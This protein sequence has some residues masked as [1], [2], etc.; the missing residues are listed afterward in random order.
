M[1][2]KSAV[3]TFGEECSVLVWRWRKTE[4]RRFAGDVERIGFVGASL[5]LS[6]YD[7]KKRFERHSQE[8]GEITHYP[9]KVAQ[10]SQGK[11]VVLEGCP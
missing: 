9:T 10:F 1:K 7:H 3:I 6:S 8:L 2:A 11:F 5:V 4:L